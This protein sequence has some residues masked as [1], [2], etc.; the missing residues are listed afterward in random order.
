MDI[1]TF[2]KILFKTNN[3]KLT[4][5][6]KKINNSNLNKNQ[7][8][9]SSCG[10]GKTE[11]SYY[12]AKTWNN[13]IMYAY[14]MKSLASSIYKRLNRY[15]DILSS[16]KKW[17]I[18]H[19]GENEDKFLYNDMCITTIDQ[20][21]A[22]YLGIGIQA[23]IKGKNIVRSNFIFDE[24]QLF[25]P[26]KTLKTL[27]YMLDSL[28]L[29]GNK[30]VIMTATMPEGLI[31]FL[32]NRYDM[33]VTITD[34]P[35]I[36]NRRVKLY[37]VTKLCCKAIEL[38]NKKQIVICNSQQE[39]N[40]IFDQIKD[41]GRVI[42]L[43][44]KLLKSDRERV[45]KEIFEYFGK[46]T[47]ENNKILLTTQ[48]V[49]AGMDI[50]A[51]RMYSSLSPIDS[52][53][54]R[55]GRV[56]RW[57]GNGEIIIFKGFY[58]IYDKDVCMATLNK[59]RENQGLIFSWDIQKEW[60][61]KILNPFYEKHL[62]NLN[63]FKIAMRGGNR[64]ELI[65]QIENINIIVSNTAIRNDFKRET[66]SISRSTFEKLAKQNTLYK[67]AKGSVIEVSESKVCNGDTILIKGIDCTYDKVGFRYYKGV[68][69]KPFPIANQLHKGLQFEDYIEEAWIKHSIEV[70]N[71]MKETLL[72]DRFK[73]WGNK[74]IERYSILAG[75]HDLGKL[76]TN[77]QEYIGATTVPLAHNVYD[78]RGNHG[79][80]DIKH[81]YISAIALRN[82]LNKLEFNLLLN[83]HGRVM[84][85]GVNIN[86][87]SYE[88]VKESEEL[89]RKIG[90]KD[91]VKNSGGNED[92]LDK[93]LITP[94][95]K[96]WVDFV[97]LEGSLMEADI[98]AIKRVKQNS[99][100]YVL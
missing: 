68:I 29:R 3:V 95:D 97:Y 25:E 49:E 36:E 80:R 52:L 42:L 2:F 21:L 31:N 91:S 19:S 81:N 96:E 17:S 5:V 66:V 53:I 24:I 46:G 14:P 86:L 22:G 35:S 99:S 89:L 43:N 65:R 56:C 23:F 10:S 58:H 13:K 11:A 78:P 44:N 76:T 70:K 47:L 51:T 67:L 72:S 61:N 94:V 71:V 12:I 30:F 1:D 73:S 90:Y 69:A 92:I 98:E 16:G 6:Q 41:K 50:S 32:S 4:E 87:G 38:Y 60:V 37:Y 84:P 82:T 39:Q 20:I 77:W 100:I 93:H 28:K 34:D 85:S 15:E 62:K 40:E 59:V 55:E 33:E 54:Q 26:E 88:L 64:D 9:L 48:I 7:L 63:R 45:E 74:V 79:I 83:H 27:I 75:I 57:G 18:Q 8:I